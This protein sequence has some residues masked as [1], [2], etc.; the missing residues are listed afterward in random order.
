MTLDKKPRNVVIPPSSRQ[1]K[2]AMLPAPPILLEALIQME[3]GFRDV[4]FSI[5]IVMAC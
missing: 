3:H 5:P 1:M 4:S 2:K